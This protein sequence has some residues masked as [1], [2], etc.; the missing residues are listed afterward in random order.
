M[1][2]NSNLKRKPVDKLFVFMKKNQGENTTLGPEIGPLGADIVN[3]I[4]F[5]SHATFPVWAAH[6][7]NFRH[8]IKIDLFLNIWDP[9]CE[10]FE[11][12]SA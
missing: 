3:G 12:P 2:D 4:S 5:H 7:R 10:N 8:A 11:C 1:V 6:S 9:V